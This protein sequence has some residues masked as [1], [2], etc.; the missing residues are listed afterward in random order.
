MFS[1]SRIVVSR[2]LILLLSFRDVAIHGNERPRDRKNTLQV[3]E[4]TPSHLVLATASRPRIVFSRYCIVF[5]RCRGLTQG[6]TV[7]NNDGSQRNTVKST[8]YLY[9]LVVWNLNPCYLYCLNIVNYA[10]E[11]QK[12]VSEI[13][14]F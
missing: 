5:S 11:Q 7:R 14:V 12:N 6:G 9:I 10:E 13:S 1:L 3:H 8:Y 4:N 2:P